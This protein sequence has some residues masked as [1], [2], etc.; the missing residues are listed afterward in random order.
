MRIN[1]H[2]PFV[3][4]L[5]LMLAA[6]GCT[7][8]QPTAGPVSPTAPAEFP[9]TLAA[10]TPV[11]LRPLSGSGG[12]VIAFSSDRSGQPGIYVMNADGSD[13]RLVTDKDNPEYAA[14]SPDGSRI[15]YVS[16]VP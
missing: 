6:V 7:A 16:S 3:R 13:Q 11:S 4:Y 9:P 5:M 15:V 10:P 2:V 1:R 12:G 14:F 8:T